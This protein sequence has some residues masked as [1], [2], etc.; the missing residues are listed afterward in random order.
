VTLQAQTDEQNFLF[1]KNSK[2]I[3]HDAAAKLGLD[4]NAWNS[5]PQKVKQDIKLVWG[6]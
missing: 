2:T 1:G 6:R 4:A 5:P 3:N